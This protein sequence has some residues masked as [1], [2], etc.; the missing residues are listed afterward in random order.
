MT[1]IFSSLFLILLLATAAHAGGI[2]VIAN[3]SFSKSA[4]SASQVKDIYLGKTEV[5]DGV[6]LS[7]LDR[8]DSEAVKGDFLKKTLGM[9]GDEYKSYWVKRVFKD[10]GAPPSVKAS[11]DDAIKAVKEN[12]GAIA[13]VPEEDLKSKEGLKVLIT[14]K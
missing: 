1:R 7:P 10:G 13:Y 3:N 9:T 5:M 6:R 4:L 12:K 8:K 14:I 2:S 11:S